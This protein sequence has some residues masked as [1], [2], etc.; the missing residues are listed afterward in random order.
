MSMTSQCYG[1]GTS[2]KAGTSLICKN[3]LQKQLKPLP[4]FLE[5]MSE[6]VG[7]ALLF[8]LSWRRRS[9]IYLK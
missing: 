7:K 2:L 6:A 3:I 4:M 9:E 8:L 5:H 1:N